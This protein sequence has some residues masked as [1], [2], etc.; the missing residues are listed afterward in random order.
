[1]RGFYLVLALA[2]CGPAAAED[3]TK[4]D[5]DGVSK[6]LTERKL[7]YDDGASQTFRAGGA[8][9]YDSGGQQSSG[10]WDVRGDQYCSV[11]P[12]SDSWACYE[13]E[14]MGMEIRFVAADGSASTGHYLDLN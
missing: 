6:A 1:M 4:L 9:Y 5:G 14:V 7:G 3:W 8:T 13:V 2:L 12:P 11:W 10:R